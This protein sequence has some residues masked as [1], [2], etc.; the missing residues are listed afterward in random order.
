ME[1]DWLEIVL[2][3]H[4]RKNR[5]LFT[6]ESPCLQ[7]LLEILRRQPRLAVVQWALDCAEETAARLCQR[8]PDDPRPQEALELCR[9]WV[10]GTIR[11]NEARPAILA[12]HAAAK[13]TGDPVT[14]ALYHALG[15]GC[16]AVHTEAH[17]IGLPIYELT[18]LALEYSLENCR[19]VVENQIHHYEA[20]LL[21]RESLEEK[22]PWA[23]FLLRKRPNREQLLYEKKHRDAGFPV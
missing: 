6:R 2:E 21:Y 18:A 3:K 17:A 23:P 9:L 16:S 15:Q 8:V 12:V 1:T 13:E 7:N 20:L 11:M 10:H 4:K 22:G 5:V 14:A 19:A